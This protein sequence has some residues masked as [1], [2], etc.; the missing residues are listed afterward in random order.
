M[1]IALILSGCMMAALLLVLSTQ[2]RTTDTSP[3]RTSE[4]LADA[5]SSHGIEVGDASASADTASI[6]TAS[7]SA[8]NASASASAS[9]TSIVDSNFKPVAYR[10]AGT[11]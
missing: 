6:D 4:A 5:M 11:R 1:K 2:H 3:H 7:I 10:Q 9:A 8:A